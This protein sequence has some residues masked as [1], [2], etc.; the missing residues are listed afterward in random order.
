MISQKFLDDVPLVNSDFVTLWAASGAKKTNL[1]VNKL[2]HHFLEHIQFDLNVSS[3]AIWQFYYEIRRAAGGPP[4]FLYERKW[5]HSLLPIS[6]NETI[7]DKDAGGDLFNI[8]TTPNIWQAYESCP[9]M[10]PQME[11]V[12]TIAGGFKGKSAPALPVRTIAGGFGLLGS[13]MEYGG[14]LFRSISPGELEAG[15]S[16]RTHDLTEVPR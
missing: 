1:N 8:H 7:Q 14:A 12:R 11:N 16:G 3:E 6:E 10:S 2:E 5:T 4:F 9:S 15:G 13:V